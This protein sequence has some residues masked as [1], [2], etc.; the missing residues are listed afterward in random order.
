MSEMSEGSGGDQAV[1][2][3][4]GRLQQT[5]LLVQYANSDPGGLVAS[6]G[7][8]TSQPQQGEEPPEQTA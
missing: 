8:D 2:P 6:L 7:V 3:D 5:Q 1:Q 4:W